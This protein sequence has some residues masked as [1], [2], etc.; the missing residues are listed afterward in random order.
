[1]PE[2]VFYLL[3]G[4]YMSDTSSG[5]LGVI[6]LVP[7]GRYAFDPLIKEQVMTSPKRHPDL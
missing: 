1:M 3:K 2:A 5:F 7:Q 6:L 4:D